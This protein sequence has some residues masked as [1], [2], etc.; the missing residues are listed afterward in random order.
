[1][2]SF[3]TVIS[4]HAKRRARRSSTTLRSSTIA[5]VGIRHWAMSAQR[6]MN[7]RKVESP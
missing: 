2:N 3:T 4:L 6:S 5:S 7:N 1:M